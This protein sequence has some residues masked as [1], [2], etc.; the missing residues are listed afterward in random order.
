M[1]RIGKQPIEIPDKVKVD[2]KENNIFV[3]GPHGKLQQDICQEVT[4]K[5]EDS[6]IFISVDKQDKRSRAMH[7][8][9]RA[10]IA[11]MVKGVVEKFSK[12]LLIIGVGYRAQLKGKDLELNIGKS[13]PIIFKAPEGIEIKL[14]DPTHI[15]I[16]GVNKQLVGQVAAD[17]RAFY[18]PEP[19]KGKGIRYADEY[20][21]KKAGKTVA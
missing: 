4:V 10:L 12:K 5:Q 13:H 19:Y 14:E 3:E 21:K 18:K 16:I 20:V 11:N 2:L 9:M 8:L 1:S 6:K 15:E 7:G 17:I